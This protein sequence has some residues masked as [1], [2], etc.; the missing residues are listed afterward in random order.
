MWP[1][2]Y[3]FES[4]LHTL[5]SVY[6]EIG[7]NTMRAVE[8]EDEIWTWKATVEHQD[9]V[10]WFRQLINE[11]PPFHAHRQCFPALDEDLQLK[12]ESNDYIFPAD[13][14][15]PRDIQQYMGKAVTTELSEPEILGVFPRIAG[16]RDIM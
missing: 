10:E 13:A 5:R 12:F 6:G 2:N 7:F 3:Y 4:M 1:D 15:M 16:P 11:S 14:Q 8:R 9:T